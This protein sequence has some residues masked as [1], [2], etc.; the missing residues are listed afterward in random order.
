MVNGAAA[1]VD[2]SMQRFPAET[3]ATLNWLNSMTEPVGRA[4]NATVTYMDDT[5]G[6]V[7][8]TQ[9]NNLSPATRDAL[10]GAGKITGLAINA[11][12]C[13]YH[14]LGA[15]HAARGGL[16]TQRLDAWGVLGNTQHCLE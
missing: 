5:T 6:C 9:W 4:V 1:V 11:G 13:E 8:S 10:I 15:E 3:K 12:W 7:V 14:P 16:H 2:M